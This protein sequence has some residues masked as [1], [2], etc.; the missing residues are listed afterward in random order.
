MANLHYPDLAAMQILLLVGPTVEAPSAQEISD[1]NVAL[2][3]VI[4]KHEERGSG[5]LKEL[6]VS[7]GLLTE[8]NQGWVR[9]RV[10]NLSVLALTGE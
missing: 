10:G 6:T 5:M 2:R 8:E 9:D 4:G 7:R 3:Q 1:L